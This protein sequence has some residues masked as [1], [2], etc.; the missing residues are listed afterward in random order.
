M[1]ARLERSIICN[2]TNAHFN[3]R[4]MKIATVPCSVGADPEVFSAVH[5]TYCARA[6]DLR[7]VLHFQNVDQD[8]TIS[9]PRQYLS[10][11]MKQ[12]GQSDEPG[13]MNRH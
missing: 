6:F 1:I 8:L 13:G 11:T 2:Q 10:H 12:I 3:K 5:N 4:T 9:F 7:I